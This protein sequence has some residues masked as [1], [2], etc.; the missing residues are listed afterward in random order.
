MPHLIGTHVSRTSRPAA[1]YR[2]EPRYVPQAGAMR[3][4]PESEGDGDAGGGEEP[5]IVIIS[6]P[7]AV[8][9]SMAD[10]RLL[11]GGDRRSTERGY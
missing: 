8:N 9:P 7:Q 6:K 5:T 1:S 10:E 11:R 4:A 2:S 3:W